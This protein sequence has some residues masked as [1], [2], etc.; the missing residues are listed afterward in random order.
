MDRVCAYSEAGMTR[1]TTVTRTKR[2]VRR[3]LALASLLVFVVGLLTTVPAS[4]AA[5]STCGTPGCGGVVYNATGSGDYVYVTNGWC[6]AAGVQRSPD[7]SV[8][9]INTYSQHLTHAMYWVAPG[10][11]STSLGS[12]YY[13][14][15]GFRARGGCFTKVSQAGSI[16]AYDRRGKSDL[17]IKIYSSDHGSFQWVITS[18]TC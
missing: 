2:G 14:V 18:I 11:S 15:D 1:R 9:G 3:R 5:A 8:C 10:H 16:L 12:Y 4:P 6:T 13:D 17:W 7:L